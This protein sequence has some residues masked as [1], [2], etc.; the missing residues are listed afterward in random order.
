MLPKLQELRSQFSVVNVPLSDVVCV[1]KTVL[2]VGPSLNDLLS[3]RGEFLCKPTD[4]A[5][6]EIEAMKELQNALKLIAESWTIHAWDEF[7]WVQVKELQ[8]RDMLDLRTKAAEVVEAAQCLTCP[9][10]VRHVG[11][12]IP[13]CSITSLTIQ[14]SLECVMTNG[15]SKRTSPSS[16]SSCPTKICSSYPITSSAW[17]F[18]TS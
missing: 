4:S 12:N 9:N 18:Y 15:L 10:F 14:F 7:D 8:L 16:G 11:T 3:D 1:T 13:A 17:K 2:R 5:N 6:R